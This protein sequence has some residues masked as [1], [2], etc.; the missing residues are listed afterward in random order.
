MELRRARARAAKAAATQPATIIDNAPPYMVPEIL[1]AYGADGLDVTGKG[2]TIAILIDT[3]P[4][5]SDLKAFWKRTTACRVRVARI[6]KVNVKG[7]PLPPADGEETLDVEWASGIAPRAKVRVYACGTLQFVDLDL[8]LD[9]IIADLP[10]QPGMRQLSISLGLGEKFMG[11]PN[12]EVRTQH[13]KFLRLGR[14]RGERLC[15]L[16]RRR[17]Q[18]RRLRAQRHR[19]NPGRV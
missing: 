19:P 7:G 5:D 16:R 2:Q 15:V 9:R 10:S 14:R 11:G 4:D 1:K 8:A 18:A 6:E 3:F 13:M 17:L 12:G